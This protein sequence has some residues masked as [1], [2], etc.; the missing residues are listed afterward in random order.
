MVS[1]YVWLDF[2]WYGVMATSPSIIHHGRVMTTVRILS[3]SSYLFLPRPV[4]SRDES[5]QFNTWTASPPRIQMDYAIKF[6]TAVLFTS[7]N[8]LFHEFVNVGH[9][10]I[11]KIVKENL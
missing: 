9:I 1:R 3:F 5:P 2:I 7:Q 11:Y 6:K 4:I 10:Y 8:A